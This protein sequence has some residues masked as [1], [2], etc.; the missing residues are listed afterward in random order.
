M[1]SARQLPAGL[2]GVIAVDADEECPRD[3]FRYREGVFYAS[4]YP[5]PAGASA[6]TEN[7]KGSSFA[8][9]NMTGFA[10]RALPSIRAT[11]EL[12]GGGW[13]ASIAALR[14]TLV[15]ELVSI[16]EHWKS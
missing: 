3:E 5:R 6:Y 4:P 12:A 8:V 7:L 9:A 14:D 16:G 13:H 2:A 10:A 11:R 1:S 15:W